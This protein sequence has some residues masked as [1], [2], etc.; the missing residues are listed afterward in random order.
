MPHS[1]LGVCS[2]LHSRPAVLCP[3]PERPARRSPSRLPRIPAPAG[4]TRAGTLPPSQATMSAAQAAASA[5]P[6]S[7]EDVGALLE[8]LTAKKGDW[9]RASIDERL[10]VLA[11]IR[12]RVLD[13]AVEWAQA[14]SSVRCTPGAA[15]TAGDL[16]ATVAS[17]T[18]AID[19]IQATL[20]AYKKAGAFPAPP[21]RTT[22]AG[23]TVAKVRSAE[24][25]SLF[26]PCKAPLLSSRLSPPP[27]LATGLPLG[28]QRA[29]HEPAGAVGAERGDVPAWRCTCAREPGRVLP[30]AARRAPGGRVGGR[31]PAFSGHPGRPP[32][33]AAG[34][35]AGGGAG[36]FFSFSS[37]AVPAPGWRSSLQWATRE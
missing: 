35:A 12:A 9:A 16:V 21:T 19:A 1:T 5:A 14:S 27:S 22:P 3:L 31:Q 7:A 24:P 33:G 32:H 11:E 10:A 36:W 25:L 4:H 37:P 30:R 29:V 8:G 26:P 17:A 18:G 15:A 13:N 34:G 23:Q 20:K 28:L 6:A 2:N